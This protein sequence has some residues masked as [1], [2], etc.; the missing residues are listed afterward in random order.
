MTFESNNNL[1][2]FQRAQGR[3]KSNFPA[4]TTVLAGAS[5]DYFV[6][7]TN[8]KI[9]FTDFVTALGVTGVLTQIGAVTGTPILEVSGTNFGIRNLEDGSGVKS[10]LSPQNGAILSHNFTFDVAGAPLSTNPTALSPVIKSLIAGT[11]IGIAQG[12]TALTLSATGVTVPT[13]TIVINLESDFPEQDATTIT[14]TG[15]IIYNIGASITT[16]KRFIVNAAALAVVFTADNQ[17]GPVVTYTG[18]ADMFT[19][20]DCNFIIRDITVD[21][22][23]A[24]QTFNH[25]ETGGGGLTLHQAISMQVTNTPKWGTFTSLLVSQFLNSNARNANQGITVAGT[26]QAIFAIAEFALTSI[27]STFIFLDFGSTIIPNIEISNP[28][29]IGGASSIG[30]KGLASN[31]NVPANNLAMVENGNFDGVTTPLSGITS[32]DFRWSFLANT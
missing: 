32:D 9:S 7:G 4:K 15:G 28:I 20:V 5:L 23:N 26:G 3:K 18:I 24:N 27:N 10:Q 30:I 17:F 31:G 12:A 2:G 16:S 25:S 19:I 6:D 14:L 11:G 13:D 22:P 21:S 8:F 1:S 29:A